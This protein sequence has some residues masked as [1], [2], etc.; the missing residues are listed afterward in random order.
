MS[1]RPPLTGLK[2]LVVE[3]VVD[4]Q[5]LFRI[6][7][8]SA[9]ATVDIAVNGAEAVKNAS[10]DYSVILM[11]VQMP[12]LDGLSA[13]RQLRARG[14]TMPIIALTAHAMPEEVLKSKN[15]GCTDHIAKP[16][17]SKILISSILRALHL[18]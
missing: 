12:V 15:A 17:S 11:D 6:F 16:V 9:G 18:D 8:E 14:L 7:L 1:S 13:T 2:L 4:N 10:S 5:D 3:D